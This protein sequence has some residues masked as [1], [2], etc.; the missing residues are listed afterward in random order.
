M[1]RVL[2]VEVVY[3]FVFW[4]FEGFDLCVFCFRVYVYVLCVFWCDVYLCV[5]VYAFF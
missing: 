1:F 3:M 5:Y 2:F 4:V